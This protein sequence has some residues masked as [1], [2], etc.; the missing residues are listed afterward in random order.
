MASPSPVPSL[1]HTPLAPPEPQSFASLKQAKDYCAQHSK[2]HGYA[3]VIAHSRSNKVYMKCDR[4]GKY[5]NQLKHTEASRVRK[6]STK[7]IGC[8]FSCTIMS[9]IDTWVLKILDPKHNHDASETPTAH[10][11]HRRLN[12]EQ[13]TQALTLSKHTIAPR[14]I[15]AS[16]MNDSNVTTTTKTINNIINGAR[17]ERLHG[18]TAVHALLDD[19]KEKGYVFDYKVD[20]VGRLSHLFFAHPLSIEL[21]RCYGDTAVMDCTYKTNRYKTPYRQLHCYQS[22]ICYLPCI[23]SCRM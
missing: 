20:E 23:H 13:K 3:I 21:A 11:V 19:L 10:V 12:D 15:M 14:E 2:L 7:L 4:G 16:L 17:M 5:R 8:P 22:Y 9:F 1:N 18:R 6:M